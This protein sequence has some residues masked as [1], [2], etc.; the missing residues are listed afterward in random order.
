[1]HSLL[2]HNYVFIIFDSQWHDTQFHG[3]ITGS[4]GM[5]QERVECRYDDGMAD[6]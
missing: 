2:F 1:M 6:E 5:V 3:H 4:E